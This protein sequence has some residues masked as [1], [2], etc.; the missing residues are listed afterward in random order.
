MVHDR[1]E[2][3]LRF[4]LSRV[5]DHFRRATLKLT[6]HPKCSTHQPDTELLFVNYPFDDW[7][8]ESVTFRDMPGQIGFEAASLRVDNVVPGQS[9]FEVDLTEVVRS[10]KAGDGILTLRIRCPK[11]NIHAFAVASREHENKSIRPVLHVRT[12]PPDVPSKGR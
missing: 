9:V 10:E 3:L 4:D 2:A 11:H 8:E 5:P 1:R 7:N 12:G 6:V